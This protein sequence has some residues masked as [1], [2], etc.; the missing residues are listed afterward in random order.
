MFSVNVNRVRVKMHV[1]FRVILFIVLLF[2]FMFYI[3]VYIFAFIVA[4]FITRTYKRNVHTS[5]WP[6]NTQHIF[7]NV[8]LIQEGAYLFFIL[9][10]ITSFD[11]IRKSRIHHGNQKLLECYSYSIK[12]VFVYWSDCCNVMLISL[13]MFCFKLQNKINQ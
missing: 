1:L 4:S 8:T 2:V 9:Y 13:V 12:I 7:W 5:K 3:R 6:V 10:I 11:I